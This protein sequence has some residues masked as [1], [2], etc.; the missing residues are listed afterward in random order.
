M[1][2]WEVMQH[3]GVRPWHDGI[4]KVAG[5][6]WHSVNVLYAPASSD[7]LAAQCPS[8]VHTHLGILILKCSAGT[9]S[10]IRKIYSSRGKC[11]I[12][13]VPQSYHFYF[14]TLS[15][16]LHSQFWRHHL[17]FLPA[18]VSNCWHW[19]FQTY[20]YSASLFAIPSSDEYRET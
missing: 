5:W 13:P 9:Q 10:S 6:Y 7:K 11:L 3:A 8:A 4:K 19:I 16:S 1:N 12:F 14:P 15:E 17:L 2:S 20:C 18:A